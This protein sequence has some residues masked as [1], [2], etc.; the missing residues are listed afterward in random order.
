MYQ[1]E[2]S[3]I[4]G[5]ILYTLIAFVIFSIFISLLLIAI[6]PISTLLPEAI[7]LTSSAADTIDTFVMLI[8]IT[9]VIFALGISGY[10]MSTSMGSELSTNDYI[11][12]VGLI[13]TGIMMGIMFLYLVFPAAMYV[14]YAIE[15]SLPAEMVHTMMFSEWGNG[16]FFT[17][18]K[19][20]IEIMCWL[21]TFVCYTLFV[22]K[23][24]KKI[25]KINKVTEEYTEQE[26]W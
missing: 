24:I 4:T 2:D 14:F 13:V 11:E 1:N 22:I 5:G 21:P 17:S 6:D 8:N 25:V 3:G 7:P 15:S 18:S 16:S 26:V 19:T 12:G 9:P 10:V 20:L 23:P